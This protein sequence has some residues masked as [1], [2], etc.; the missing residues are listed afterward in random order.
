MAYNAII[1]LV[2]KEPGLLKAAQSWAAW[3]GGFSRS[4]RSE[5]PTDAEAIV[6]IEHA[7]RMAVGI[8]NGKGM[9]GDP[10]GAA[11]WLRAQLVARFPHAA[12]RIPTAETLDGWLEKH[13]PEGK[14]GKLTTAGIVTNIVGDGG[15]VGASKDRQNLLER[16]TKNLDRKR[17]PRW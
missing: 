6:G 16:V 11:S 1:A 13:A 17:H 8:R 12:D 10:T 4:R 2:K 15:L 7:V 14:K 9:W 3:A 5:G